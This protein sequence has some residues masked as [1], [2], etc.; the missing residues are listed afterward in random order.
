MGNHKAR[1]SKE[2]NKGLRLRSCEEMLASAALSNPVYEMPL[3]SLTAL[4]LKC[5]L[6]EH[7]SNDFRSNDLDRVVCDRPSKDIQVLISRDNLDVNWPSPHYV[8]RVCDL[9]GVQARYYEAL[10]Q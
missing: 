5:S 4:E 7:T 2:A 9:A 8:G 3:R 10:S 6:S 1:T